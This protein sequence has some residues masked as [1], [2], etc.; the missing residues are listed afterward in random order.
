MARKPTTL[1]LGTPDGPI[2][3][4][5]SDFVNNDWFAEIG[6]VGPYAVGKSGAAVDRIGRRAQQYPGSNTLLARATLTSLKDSTLDR[7]RQRLGPIIASEN[8]QEAIFRLAPEPH[9]VTGHLVQST[10]NGIGLDRTDIE[11]VLKSTEYFSVHLEEADEIPSPAQDL[12][13]E[14]ARQQVFH[15]ELTVWHLCVEL[16]QVWSIVHGRTFTPH[17]VHAI[18][19]DD[20]FNKVGQLQMPMD[21]PMPGNPSVSATWNPN[22]N[23][24][25]WSRYV[26]VPYPYPAPTPEWVRSNVGIRDIRIPAA[27]LREDKF[28]FRAGSIAVPPGGTKGFVAKHNLKE[29][30]VR[31]VSG[32]TYA[33]DQVDLVVQRYAIYGFSH[34]NESRDYGNVENSYLMMDQ[35]KRRKHQLGHVDTKEGRVTP[36]YIDEPFS[37]GGHVVEAIDRERI[38]RSGNLIVIGLDHGGDHPTA[39]AIAMYLPRTKSL[40]FFDEYLKSGQSAYANAIEIQQKRVPGLEHLVGYDPAMNG[41]AFLGDDQTRY[42][43]PYIEVFGDD[44]VFPAERGD[45]PFDTLA[46]MLE[47]EDNFLPGSSAAMP[48][49]FVTENCTHIRSA[50]LNLT[51]DMIARKRH[52]WQVDMGDACKYAVSMVKKGFVDVNKVSI[53]VTPRLPFSRKFKQ[54]GAGL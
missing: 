9:P 16:A 3:Y 17:D 6:F 40:I 49:I 39:A 22:G 54:R 25:M 34:E 29:G 41:R 1:H 10:I 19:L 28:Q 38:A 8:L 18:L 27:T 52:L 36:G 47:F 7:L 24:H 2:K 31:F 21:H 45:P 37:Y 13:Q 50:F 48:R 33:H 46:Q 42:I 35:K 14:R 5:Y 23:D 53:D 26:G 12:V 11:Q 30:T 20:Q 51:W 15:R 32:Q 43:D 4:K 44:N